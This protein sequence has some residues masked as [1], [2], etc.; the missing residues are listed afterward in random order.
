MIVQGDK[1]FD[2]L[3]FGDAQMGIVMESEQT[4]QVVTTM[5]DFIL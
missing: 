5:D 3:Y 1:D 4:F 2:Q